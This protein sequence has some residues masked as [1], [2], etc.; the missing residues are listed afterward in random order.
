[1][2]LTDVINNEKDKILFIVKS[3][4]YIFI[5]LYNYSKKVHS[6][7]TTNYALLNYSSLG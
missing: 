6:L 5:I 2:L 7:S 4:N 1:M 3:P